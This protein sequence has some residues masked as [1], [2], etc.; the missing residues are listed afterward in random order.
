MKTCNL[1]KLALLSA[2][3][4]TV[5]IGGA[6]AQTT[7]QIGGQV[8]TAAALAS[9][10]GNNIDFGTW[11]MNIAGG[12]TPTLALTAVTAGSP[13][14]PVPGGVVDPTTVMTNTVVPGVGGNVTVTSPIATTLQIEGNVTT[15]FVDGNLSLGTLVYTDTVATNV[16]IPA[17]F[18]GATFATVVAGGVA[19]TVGIGGTLTVG[20]GGGTPAAATTFN[21][22]LVDISFTY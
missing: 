2:V 15:D 6:Q 18:D 1:K 5:G 17:A 20:G 11:A 4:L 10:A 3:A 14:V 19:E 13:P 21:D 9:A 12:D 8:S 7:A 16:A 22:A